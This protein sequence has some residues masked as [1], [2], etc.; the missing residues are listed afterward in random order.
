MRDEYKYGIF[1]VLKNKAKGIGNYIPDHSTQNEMN[2]TELAKECSLLTDVCKINVLQTHLDPKSGALFYTHK[3]S[4]EGMKL[5]KT[6]FR[7]Y[8]LEE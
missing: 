3:T 7:D 8:L 5:L 4:V 6:F 1:S 2:I